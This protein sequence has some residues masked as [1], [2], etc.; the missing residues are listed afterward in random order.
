MIQRPLIVSRLTDV[1]NGDDADIDLADTAL[2]LATLDHPDVDLHP[3][4]K[5]LS[6]LSDEARETVKSGDTVV[7]QAAALKSLL[8]N[9]FGFGG[10][11]ETYDDTANANL[12]DVIDRRKGLPVALGILYIHAARA[13][14]SRIEG[15]NFPSHFM[16]RISGRGQRLIIDPFNDGEVVAPET[17]RGRLKEL[18]GADAELRSDHYSALNNRDILI[19]LQNNIKL[20]AIAGGDVARAVSVLQ[21]LILVA[22]ERPEMWWETAVLLSRLGNVK[23][24]IATL[25]QG[26][27]Y[28]HGDGSV[29]QLQDLL[30]KL[31]SQV[32]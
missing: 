25:E 28:G 23:Q 16:V 21:A 19:R 9:S 6:T 2:L 31:R 32:N 8:H 29:N 26:L 15:L 22:P 10:D 1:G 3:Y 18:H 17:M 13:A 20:R 11:R 14:G 30:Y 4:R 7:R 27:Q 24:A 12:M 5:F